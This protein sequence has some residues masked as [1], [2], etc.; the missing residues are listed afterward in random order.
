MG[1]RLPFLRLKWDLQPRDGDPEAD[2]H[3]AAS[4]G[5]LLA[6]QRT[7]GCRLDQRSQS[8]INTH[9][10]P[11]PRSPRSPVAEGFSLH[12]DRLHAERRARPWRPRPLAIPLALL[13]DWLLGEP[14]GVLHPVV[15]MGRAI[16][17]LEQR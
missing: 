8:L 11:Q 13:L 5:T 15:W 12:A 9:H 17:R 2:R 10:D 16:G 4:R 7:G 14:P 6:S 1:L 3:D